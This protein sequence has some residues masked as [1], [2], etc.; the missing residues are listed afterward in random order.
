[1]QTA[2]DYEKYWDRYEES[3]MGNITY[4]GGH[5]T[6][7]DSLEHMPPLEN[8]SIDFGTMAITSD[9]VAFMWDRILKEWIPQ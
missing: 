8:T 6:R 2:K 7:T 5:S 1:M 3:K 9:G 4:F